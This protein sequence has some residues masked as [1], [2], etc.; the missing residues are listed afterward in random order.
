MIALKS[1]GYVTSAEFIAEKT[2]YPVTA[3]AVATAPAPIPSSGSKILNRSG[4]EQ[5]T[6]TGLFDA[7]RAMA[8]SSIVEGYRDAQKT[9]DQT[10][11]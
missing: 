7:L 2:G 11:K 9:D 10:K 8:E 1:G 4:E 3:E 5:K 6:G